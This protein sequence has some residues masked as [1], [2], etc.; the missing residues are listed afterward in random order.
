MDFINEIT[1]SE[2]FYGHFSDV[3]HFDQFKLKMKTSYAENVSS[4]LTFYMLNFNVELLRFRRSMFTMNKI[5]A[6]CFKGDT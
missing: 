5:R 2:L 4:A 6:D 1:K 3:H